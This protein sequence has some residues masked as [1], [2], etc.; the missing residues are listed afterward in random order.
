MAAA[1]AAALPW[2]LRALAASQAPADRAKYSSRAVSLVERALVIDMLAPLK[3][4]FSPEAYADRLGPEQLAMFRASGI[5]GFHS[6]MGI[7]GPEAHAQAL[8][9]LAAWQGFVGRHSE[10]FCLVGTAADLDRAKAQGKAAVIMGVQNA[11]HF[12][13]V[14][15]V[16]TFHQLGQRCAQLTY[17]RQTLVGSGA[18]DRIDGGVSDYGAQII[19]AMNAVGMLVDVSHCGDRTTLD[20][21]EISAGPIAITHSNCRALN[22]HPRLKTDEAIRKLAAR[23][24]VMGITGVRNFV[25]DREPTNVDHMVDHIDHVAKLVGI[26]HVGIGSDADLNGYDDMPADQLKLLRGMY[27]SSY[28]FRDKLDTDGFDHPKKIYDLTDAL[29]RRGYSDSDIELVLGGNFRRLLGGIW[30]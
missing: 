3:I 13:T 21:I 29:I 18:T 11:E 27:K 16:K 17:N 7:E 4:D 8:A 22:N 26:E 1:V 20:A 12:R 30:T 19:K 24:G 9:Y 15:D 6:A 25:R 14:D 2:P 10:A 23:G 28:A 5:T